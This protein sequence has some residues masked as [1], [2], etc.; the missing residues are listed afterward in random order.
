MQIKDIIRVLHA[1]CLLSQKSKNKKYF[2]FNINVIYPSHSLYIMT[3]VLAA[4]V[5]VWIYVSLNDS[6]YP[7]YILYP[8]PMAVKIMC[9]PSR[10]INLYRSLS[11]AMQHHSYRIA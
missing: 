6:L 9:Y 4:H 3:A 8:N 7:S 10:G 11:P 1:G 5:A 2:K